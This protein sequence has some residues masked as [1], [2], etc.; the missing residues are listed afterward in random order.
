MLL[1]AKP[2]QYNNL[3]ESYLSLNP[4]SNILKRLTQYKLTPNTRQSYI[5]VIYSYILCYTLHYQEVQPGSVIIL[6]EWVGTRIFR[7]TLPKQGQINPDIVL[8]Y[9]S[10]LKS[11]HIDRHPILKNFY[12]SWMAL[13][14][15]LKDNFF[16]AK[17]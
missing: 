1:L 17:N 14:M 11:N 7:N 13:I 6:N 5:A 10:T 12:N 9:L 2:V 15:E 3:L 8:K 16:S 4:D